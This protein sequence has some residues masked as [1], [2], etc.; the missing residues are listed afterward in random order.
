MALPKCKQ[1]T[2]EMKPINKGVCWCPECG[3]VLYSQQ[4]TLPYELWYKPGYLFDLKWNETV[5]DIN[6]GKV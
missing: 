6:E 1:C 5:P 2:A 4:I 3:V